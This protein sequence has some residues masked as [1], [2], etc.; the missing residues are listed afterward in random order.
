MAYLLPP[1][2]PPPVQVGVSPETGLVVSEPMWL[3]Q[4]STVK[5]VGLS[6]GERHSAAVS[7]EGV[8]WT[9]GDNRWAH[10]G[11]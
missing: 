2:S 7:T 9:W 1:C 11:W 3:T 10:V 4:L 6:G 5:V 8:V